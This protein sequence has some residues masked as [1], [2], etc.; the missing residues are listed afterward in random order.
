VGVGGYVDVACSIDA[1][2]VCVVRTISPE[3][4]HAPA[5]RCCTGA[6]IRRMLL[7][8]K[9]GWHNGQ[10]VSETQFE[11]CRLPLL[12]TTAG[13]SGCFHYYGKSVPWPRVALVGHLLGDASRP[14]EQ[15]AGV[16]ELMLGGNRIM[17]PRAIKGN[18]RGSRFCNRKKLWGPAP[19]HAACCQYDE[20]PDCTLSQHCCVDTFHRIVC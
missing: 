1:C 6:C 18:S 8:A 19:Q 14:C 9:Q 3:T 4:Y 5:G 17:L 10:S 13:R 15:M 2:S 7:E 20:L 11:A 12:L 16:S